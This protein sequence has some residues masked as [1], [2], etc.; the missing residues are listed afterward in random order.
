ML[1]DSLLAAVTVKIYLFNIIL[2]YK[3]VLFNYIYRRGLGLGSSV[4]YYYSFAFLYL[5]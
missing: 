2:L 4:R 1:S 3:N 5:F